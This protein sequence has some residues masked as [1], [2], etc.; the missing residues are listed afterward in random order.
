MDF[1]LQNRKI[2]VTGGAGGIGSVIVKKLLERDVIVAAVDMDKEKLLQLAE[3]VPTE[4]K[5]NFFYYNLDAG[6][7]TS[8]KKMVEEF[9]NEHGEINAL[10]NN[11]AILIDNLLVSVFRN[12]INK[13]PLENWEKT[14]KYNLDS[15]F[16]F[17][18]EVAEK[19]ILKRTAGVIINVGSISAAGNAGQS[20]YA[21]SKGAMNALTFTWAKELSMFN[22]RVAGL[23]PGITDTEMPKN[24]MSQN[25]LEEWIGKTPLKRMGEPEEIADAAIF[26]LENDFFCGRILEIDGGLRM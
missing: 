9:F 5:K 25:M 14:L 22:I 4:K 21:A 11:A 23:A 1:K 15:C 8:V 2:I 17:S 3:R 12:K 18:R 26:I 6:D 16:Y 19:M 13:L 24:A 10:I 7:F 20:C